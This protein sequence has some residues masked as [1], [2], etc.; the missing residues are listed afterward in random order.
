MIA[1]VIAI[2]VMLVS[3]HHPP[4]LGPGMLLMWGVVF[5]AI[6]SAISYF[7]KFW[8]KVDDRV[9]ARRRRELLALERRRQHELR[10]QR[11]SKAG[12]FGAAGAE[13]AVWKPPDVN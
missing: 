10:R 4:L 13:G 8:R 7:N 6:L 2:S 12:A 1:Q 5:F 9:K 11:G 3:L